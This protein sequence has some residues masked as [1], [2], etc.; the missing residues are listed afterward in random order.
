ML[1][2]DV[3][4]TSYMTSIFNMADV[5][6]KECVLLMANP[7]LKLNAGD[8]MYA[9]KRIYHG[10]LVRIEK[11]V[12]RDHC[13]ASLGSIEKSDPQDHCLASLGRA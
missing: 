13:L 11:S 4:V 8:Q 2:V 7:A 1:E 6:I 10:W 5:N 3:I 9:R 12:P